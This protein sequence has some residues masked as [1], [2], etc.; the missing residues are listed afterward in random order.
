MP[1]V[2]FPK[3]FEALKNTYKSMDVRA[4]ILRF[5]R[6]WNNIITIV[7]FSCFE[8]TELSKIKRTLEEEY[9]ISDISRFKIVSDVLGIEELGQIRKMLEAGKLVIGSNEFE[10]ADLIHLDSLQCHFGGRTRRGASYPYILGLSETII[11]TVGI[12]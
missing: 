3:A 11:S 4:G 2:L 7:R 5:D 12:E 8:K 1:T 9:K 10:L 6:N